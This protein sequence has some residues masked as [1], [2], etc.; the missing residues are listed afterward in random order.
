MTWLAEI[1][2]AIR[3]F[4]AWAS[5]LDPWLCVLAVLIVLSLETSLFVGLLVP[6]EA[7]LL[8]AVGVL[9]ARWA[10][11]LFGVAVL[12]NLI[13]QTGGYWLG[14]TLGPGLRRTWAGRKIGEQRWAAAEAVVHGSGGRALITTRFVAVVHAVVPAVVGTLR[15]PFRRF[16]LLAAVGAA[17]WAAVLTTAAVALG[18]AARVVG[19][20]WMALLLT[21]IGGGGAGVVLIRAARRRRSA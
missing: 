18:E 16:L 1:D 13:G 21:C 17:L 19:Y 8:L 10:L 6:G 2:T 20:G 5:A 14:R 9:G 3:D 12:A 11:P 7:A 15:M 4:V